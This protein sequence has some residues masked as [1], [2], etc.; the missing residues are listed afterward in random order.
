MSARETFTN[1]KR[2]SSEAS[3]NQSVTIGSLGTIVGSTINNFPEQLS[4]TISGLGADILNVPVSP[5]LSLAEFYKAITSPEPDKLTGALEKLTGVN[6]T[7]TF[8]QFT[9]PINID[10]RLRENAVGLK[11]QIIA[12]IRE[13]I[14]R[15]LRS[16]ISINPILRIIL[17]PAG[18]LA[19]A[20]AELRLKIQRRIQK[21]I[22]GILYRK[23]K[24]QRV[25]I[26]RQRILQAV[27][28]ICPETG[29][30]KRQRTRR[31][32]VERNFY[33][34]STWK[35]SSSLPHANRSD[36]LYKQMSS[37]AD[38]AVDDI[39]SDTKSQILDADNMSIDKYLTPTGVPV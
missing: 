19:R 18:A 29:T 38:F 28:F 3:N 30:A 8:N 31:P 32:T 27:R 17:D 11:E 16:I 25:A 23:L 22:E 12:E 1:N 9:S 37:V 21:E 26:F 4:R 15:H 24:I 34:D 10:A 5:G 14:E 36:N 33:I 6:L 35:D 20:I 2:V 39:I 13:C 7:A